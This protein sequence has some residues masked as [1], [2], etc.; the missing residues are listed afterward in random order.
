MEHGAHIAQHHLKNYVKKRTVINVLKNH[1]HLMK[2][3]N[4]GVI[5]MILILESFL[6]V[7]Q[8]NI[9]LIAIHV[10]IIFIGH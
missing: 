10:I 9:T 8:K 3:Q 2:N 6:S 7:H 1:L 5:R 4:I